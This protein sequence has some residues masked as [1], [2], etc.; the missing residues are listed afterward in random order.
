MAI[1]QKS[2]TSIIDSQKMTFLQYATIIICF[3]MNMLDGMDVLVIAFT[4]SSITNE[5]VISSEALG[6]VFSAAVAGMTLGALFIAPQADRIGR[7]TMILICAVLMGTSIFVTSFAQSVNELMILRFISGLGIGGMLASV[8]TLASEYA[9]S[10]SKDF[11]VSLVMGGY[12][13]GAVMAGLV[14]AQIIPNYGWRTMFQFAG[15]ATL[16]T[17]PFIVIFLAESLEYLVKRRPK[18]ALQRVNKILVRMKAASYKKLVVTDEVQN[19]SSVRSLFAGE[20]K[21]QT[22]L[23]W[24]AFFMAFATLYFLLSWIPKLTTAAG[25]SEQLGIYSATVFNLGSF[26]GILMLGGLSIKMGLRKTILV[27]LFAAA[28]L[29]MFFGNVTGSVMVLIMFGLI[30]FAMQGGFVGLYPLA[31]RLYPA[32]IRTTGIG[33]A[34][35]AGRFGAVVGPIIA[36]YLVGAGLSLTTNFIIFAIPCIIAGIAAFRISSE[37]VS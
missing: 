6:I 25:L 19:T 11:W 10:K 30:G 21:A 31:A 27:F 37:H 26:F 22:F 32:E 4:A 3:L 36:G 35:G 28:A 5:W 23:L 33:W 13:I 24:L 7:K 15:I 8:S 14:G 2:V 1:D 9:P 16:I 34:I 17:I 12:P 18:Y 20:R 29:M